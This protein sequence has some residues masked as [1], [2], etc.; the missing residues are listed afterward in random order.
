M[1]LPVDPLDHVRG[2]AL[3]GDDRGPVHAL[4]D[5]GVAH[6]AAGGEEDLI[7]GLRVLGEVAALLFVVLQGPAAAGAVGAGL[8][9]DLLGLLGVTAGE[10][11]EAPVDEHVAPCV[12]VLVA[13]VVAGGVEVAGVLGP[14]VAPGVGGLVVE[15]GVAGLLFVADLSRRD[16]EQ[17]R[18][19]AGSGRCRLLLVGARVLVEVLLAV[20]CT[21]HAG[22]L[23]LI[24][25]PLELLQDDVG[26]L[27][28]GRGRLQD[29]QDGRV[30]LQLL[31]EVAE[32]HLEVADRLAG[33]FG[34]VQERLLPRPVG[35]LGEAVARGV[36]DEVAIASGVHGGRVLDVGHAEVF[37]VAVLQVG[38]DQGALCVEVP[39]ESRDAVGGQVLPAEEVPDLLG[40]VCSFKAHF[41]RPPFRFFLVPCPPVPTPAHGSGP[42]WS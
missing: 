12:A 13:V 7:A 41:H 31:P 37:L 24:R 10:L 1:H 8:T 38:R 11:V 3:D 26:R 9:L 27:P 21:P 16:L 18:D 40:V 28:D 32:L 19:R 5:A 33:G 25:R 17:S 20:A 23:A 14:V 22:R 29:L 30:A 39:H 35:P 6:V 34:I 42:W 4:D 2:V 15:L 36:A